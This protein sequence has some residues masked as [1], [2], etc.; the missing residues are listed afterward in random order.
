MLKER[1]VRIRLVLDMLQ[2]VLQQAA[3]PS[4]ASATSESRN[5]IAIMSKFLS[6]LSCILLD[7]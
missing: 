5:F 4:K 7:F 2:V 6:L 1:F 3:A